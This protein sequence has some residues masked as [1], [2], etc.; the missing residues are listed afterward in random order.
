VNSAKIMIVPL[1]LVAVTILGGCGPGSPP[2]TATAIS[3][4]PISATSCPTHERADPRRPARPP[5]ATC[6]VVQTGLGGG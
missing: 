5:V 6:S 4:Q 2:R 3:T 1:A